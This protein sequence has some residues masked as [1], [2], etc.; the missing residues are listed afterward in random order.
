MS[1]FLNVIKSF[2]SSAEEFSLKLSPIT[3]IKIFKN[4][5]VTHN[6]KSNQK[7]IA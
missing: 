4:I 1:F 2:S 5:R 3:A 7:T 6:T